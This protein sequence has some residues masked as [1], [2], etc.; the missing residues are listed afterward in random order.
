MEGGRR[1]TWNGKMKTREDGHLPVSGDIVEQLY[2]NVK[3]GG[4]RDSA[5][6]PR[7]GEA[8]FRQGASLS[9]VPPR[10]GGST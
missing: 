5:I 2:Y 7:F 4:M 10:Y 6:S 1:R 8:R 9:G 3:T